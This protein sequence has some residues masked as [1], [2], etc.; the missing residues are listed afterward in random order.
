[1]KKLIIVGAGGYAQEVLWLA[2][3]INLAQPA[4]EL[5]GFIDPAAPHRKG[6]FHYDRPILGGWDDAPAGD[7]IYFACA[8]GSPA[9]RAR[10]C[11]E[12]DRRRLKPATL[13]HPT[14]ILARH[15]E[16]G[17]GTIV[18]AHCAL[19]PYSVLGRHCALN[20]WVFA[21]HNSRVGDYCVLSPSVQVLGA[22]ALDE[23]VFVGARASI[24][25]GCRVGAGSIVGAHAFVLANV[26]SNTTVVGVPAKPLLRRNGNAA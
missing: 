18:G 10:E 24:S 21:G 8:I 3:D 11:A 1:M 7:D 17:A 4:W 5:L 16:V 9:A 6:E 14:A 19:E 20:L 23:R 26:A 25:P 12:A 15:V 2:D 22:A 13:V